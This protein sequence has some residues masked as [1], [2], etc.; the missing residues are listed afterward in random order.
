MRGGAEDRSDLHL[1]VQER[2]PDAPTKQGARINGRYPG[3][4][5]VAA[6]QGGAEE[7]SDAHLNVRERA[8]QATT[9]Q[10]GRINAAELVGDT[11]FEPVTSRM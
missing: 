8:P 11:G 5:Q 9:P 7:R 10:R 1:E 3:G 2:G 4:V 6:M